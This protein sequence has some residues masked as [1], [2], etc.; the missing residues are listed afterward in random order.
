MT[1]QLRIIFPE[2]NNNPKRPTAETTA[3]HIRVARMII[4]RDPRS[5]F[6]K[7]LEDYFSGKTM[8]TNAHDPHSTSPE[9]IRWLLEQDGCGGN[10]Y[11]NNPPH[12]PP[13]SDEDSRRRRLDAAARGVEIARG[14]LSSN[15]GNPAA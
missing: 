9:M 2:S 3:A 4:K 6:E 1:G 15:R 12:Y 11:N 14:I 8:C 7:D 13:S 5:K 10:T